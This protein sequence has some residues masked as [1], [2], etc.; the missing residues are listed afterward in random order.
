[1]VT[2][3]LL[4]YIKN[5]TAA[6]VSRVDIERVLLGGGGWNTEDIAAAFQALTPAPAAIPKPPVT[7]PAP[8]AQPAPVAAA[9][10]MPPRA[11][12]SMSPSRHTMRLLPIV[13]ILLGLLIGGG[14]AYAYATG[15]LAALTSYIPFFNSA[16]YDKTKV[17]SGAIE[18]M[19]RINS[20]AWNVNLHLFTQAR[21]ANTQ[22]L[23][24]A[25]SSQEALS[26]LT[27]AIPANFDLN[28]DVSGAAAHAGTTTNSQVAFTAD[29]TSED[30]TASLAAEFRKVGD[31]LYV[32][33]T[34]IPGIFGSFSALKNQWIEITPE[35]QKQYV[36]GQSLARINFAEQQNT[37]QAQSL[38]DLRALLELEEKDQLLSSADPKTVTL[39]GQT[40]YQYDLTVSAA[41]LP[42]FYQDGMQKFATDA[43]TTLHFDK[44]TLQYLQSQDGKNMAQYLQKNL[45]VSIWADSSGLPRKFAMSLRLVPGSTVP[46][47]ADKQVRL[48]G[49]MTLSSINQAVTIAAPTPT[50]SFAQAY[51]LA[52]GQSP[53]SLVDA[54]LKARDAVR[55]SNL[56]NIQLALELYDNDY[57]SYPSS[58][59]ALA[60]K[61]VSS[62]PTDPLDKTPYFYTRVGA[63][64]S[65]KANLESASTITPYS[66]LKT[67]SGCPVISGR[68][69]V[70]VAPR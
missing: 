4:N 48:D 62:V 10:T 69:C 7:T 58:L 27:G 14:V 54:R 31:N 12:V 34:K 16:P 32:I 24:V 33:V 47:L 13:V 11:S 52:T 51:K 20:S 59:S 2:Q 17:L 38:K 23:P 1:M 30:L 35:D 8:I 26:F 60:P 65:L 25:S 18:G 9:P 43:S 15:N 28:A 3:E 45:V 5:Q 55:I 63:S 29:L 66:R 22:P 19:S 53:Q 67:S 68:V 41:Q 36:E 64:Y 6:G 70:Q 56:Y 42:V 40:V 46:K 21:D 49:S 37:L 50:I 39:D 61:Y 44:Q 57:L